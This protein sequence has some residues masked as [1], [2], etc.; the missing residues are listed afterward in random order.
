MYHLIS[1]L[2]TISDWLRLRHNIHVCEY[3]P[4]WL[5][6]DDYRCTCGARPDTTREKAGASTKAP[7]QAAHTPHAQKGTRTTMTSIPDQRAAYVAGLRDLAIFIE[8]NPGLPLPTR[9]TT[10]PYIGGTDEEERT[11]VN[12]IADILG[13]TPATEFGRHYVAK[14]EFGPVAYQAVAIPAREMDEHHA[15]HSYSG[16]VQPDTAEVETAGADR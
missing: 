5:D 3:L 10:S 9:T 2:L 11:Q 7:A 4:D 15:L 14:R 16:S 12:R 6:P 13:V 1:A 8:N